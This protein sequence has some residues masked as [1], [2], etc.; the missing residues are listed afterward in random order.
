LI[1]IIVF[2]LLAIFLFIGLTYLCLRTLR[3]LGTKAKAAD[4]HSRWN[5]STKPAVGGIV[6]F[7]AF[8]TGFFVFYP[9]FFLEQTF[10]SV[11]IAGAIAFG[12]G[13][14]DDVS[15]ISASKKLLGQ[16]LCALVFVLG[17]GLTFR[18][19][20]E[21]QT[22]LPD[23][24]ITVIF[25]VAMMNSINMLDNMDAVA[26]I[27]SLPVFV[28]LSMGDNH[29]FTLWI[30]AAII[31][32]LVFNKNP[33]KI[34]MGDSGS[35][36]LGFVMAYLILSN[37]SNIAFLS[38]S[39]LIFILIC[40]CSIFYVDTIIVVINRLRHRVSPAIGGRDHTSHNLAYL[41]LSENTIALIFLGLG[42]IQVILFRQYYNSG[43]LELS[44]FIV[45]L[46]Y[47]ISYSLLMFWLTF[48]NLKRGK[49]QYKK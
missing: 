9:H 4:A 18:L 21:S 16:I 47:F 41:G 34:F 32:F 25:I 29:W 35:M 48:I 20:S 42:I 5:T 12:V 8:V 40:T 19:F 2:L 10:W 13:L 39:E 26:S 6:F 24:I 14:W 49:F 22:Y 37:N 38:F 1:N 27:A 31:G 43:T 28:C 17:T 46:I 30:L 11:V 15:R 23:V 44:T 36:I 45:A 33:S 3:T 7:T